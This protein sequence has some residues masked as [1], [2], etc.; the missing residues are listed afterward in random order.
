MAPKAQLRL[1]E[2]NGVYSEGP[3][4]D[5]ASEQKG[6]ESPAGLC[7]TGTSEGSPDV[8]LTQKGGSKFNI[9]SSTSNAPPVKKL[10]Y[11]ASHI[12]KPVLSH[13]NFKTCLD[14]C[15]SNR[16]SLWTRPC[17]DYSINIDCFRVFNVSEKYI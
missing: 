13:L 16:I 7:R 2:E 6:V 14:E 11:H 12:H 3:L 4:P 5:P 17:K 9:K 8:S 15:K 1:Q 10:K